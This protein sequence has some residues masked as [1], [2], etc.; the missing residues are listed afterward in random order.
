MQTDSIMIAFLQILE[1]SFCYLFYKTNDINIQI[2][3]CTDDPLQA[4][5]TADVIF[6]CLDKLWKDLKQDIAI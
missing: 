3:K 4:K 1:I 5:L 6:K 2:K